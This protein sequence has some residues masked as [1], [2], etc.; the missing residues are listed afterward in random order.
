[1]PPLRERKQDI[2]LLARH[3]LKDFSQSYNR[4]PKEISD[5]ALDALIRYPGRATFASCAT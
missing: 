3:F 2:P 1:V 4:R 5:E